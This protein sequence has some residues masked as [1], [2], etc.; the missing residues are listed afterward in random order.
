MSVLVALDRLATTGQGDVKRL[1]G[2]T[3]DLRLRV[4]NN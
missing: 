1:K 2:E 4:G 3:G